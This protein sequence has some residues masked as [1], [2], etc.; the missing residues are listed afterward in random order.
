VE[1]EMRALRLIGWGQDAVLRD[2]AEPEP[3]P[4]EVLVRIGGAGACQSDLHLM[5]DFAPGML[6][7]DP[8]FTL[9]HENAGWVEALGAGVVGLEVG[10]PVAIYG[11]WGCGRCLRCREGKENYCEHQA[12]LGAYGGGLGIDGGMA[13]FM[14][15]HA[16]HLVAL[17]SLSP[18]EAAPLTDAALTPY[19]A[20]KRSMAR[21]GA[22]SYAV[23]IG[24]GG[25]GHMAIQ[26]L[27]AC[28]A[29][30]VIAVDER[31]EALA[32]AGHAGAEHTVRAGEDAAAEIE[33]HT[34]GRGADVVLDIVGA[35]A[36][37]AL[38]ASVARQLGHLTVVGLGGGTLAFGFF[39]PRYE[40]SVASTYWGSLPELMEVIALAE[41]GQIRAQIQEFSLDEAARAYEQLAAG[42]VHGRAVVVP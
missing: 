5:H 8:P 25:L 11:P 22:G 7:W 35:D 33:S 23:V 30:T 42:D 2:V 38:G 18:V 4:G 32:L 19:H 40:V 34:R 29:A 31:P 39:S 9:G 27:A 1:V 41:R 10:T 6:P 12:A 28:T 17:D 13:P 21:L 24:A 3:G 15:V 16:R 37:L 20:I 26:I 36:T 14:R